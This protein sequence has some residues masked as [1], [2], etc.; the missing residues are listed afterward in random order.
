M[1]VTR[2]SDTITGWSYSYLTDGSGG[3]PPPGGLV[4]QDV[5]RLGHGF[6]RDIRLI[7]FWVETETVATDGTIGPGVKSF[8]T[9]SAPEFTPGTIQ[10]LTPMAMG[11]PTTV[12]TLGDLKRVD[13]ALDFASY[14][15]INGNY[16]ASG[17]AA[18]FTAP[19]LLAS[20]TN[21]EVIGLT[22]DQ[23]F[24]FGPYGQ[25]HHEPSGALMAARHHPMVKFAWQANPAFDA[26]KPRTRIKSLRFD[27]RLHLKLDRHHD[28]A[29][30]AK[31]AQLGNQ[32]GIFADSDSAVGTGIDAIT[33]AIWHLS[34][35][36]GLS[37]GSFDAAEKPLVFEVTAPGLAL[38]FPSYLKPPVDGRAPVGVRCWDN[39]HWWGARGAGQPI[40]SAPGAFHAAHL[41][42]R[43]GAAAAVTGSRSD[44][45]FNPTVYPS[46]VAARP[47][48]SGTWGPLL[49]PGIWMQTIR[50]AIV[51]NEPRLDPNTG[52]AAADL[53]KADWKTMFDPGLRATPDD[54][55]AGADIVLW[56][57]T[58]IAGRVQIPGYRG[59]S[60]L[61]TDVPGQMYESRTSGTVFLHG[62]FFA[63]NPEQKGLTVGTTAPQ[64]TPDSEAD[65]RS[66]NAWFRSAD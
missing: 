15:K 27:F 23:I 40:I 55:S 29:D 43:W 24:L 57:S 48:V 10:Q 3:T 12:T 18:T 28:L 17:I 36:K 31:L 42:W 37:G 63:H 54:I 7:G 50:F 62:M 19:A 5:D 51:R 61:P 34:A 35:S 38:G 44:P 22:I 30:N 26:T 58:E 1:T 33:G 49:D 13:T 20:A 66:A 56:F 8:H 21:P 52:V 53:S 11:T 16:V 64:Y 39:I 46:G 45:T 59:D 47:G 32:A 14:Y 60:F 25:H 4:V 2:I 41:H 6:A 65:I 9:L